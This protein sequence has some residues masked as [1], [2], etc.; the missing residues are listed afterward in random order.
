MS[1]G[2]E[3]SLIIKALQRNVTKPV[4][5]CQYHIIYVISQ[6]ITKLNDFTTCTL[7]SKILWIFLSLVFF[8]SFPRDFPVVFHAVY[9]V[10]YIGNI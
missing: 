9:L 10:Q 8:F 7:I 4:F 2:I 6:L 5:S 1:S 3:S